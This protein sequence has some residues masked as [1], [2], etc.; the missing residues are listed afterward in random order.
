MFNIYN[1][2]S[3]LGVLNI[4]SVAI[5]LLIDQILARAMFLIAILIAA[6]I[7]TDKQASQSHLEGTE[8]EIGVMEEAK[9]NRFQ[10]F[11]NF[12]LKSLCEEALIRSMN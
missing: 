12:V 8:Q 7:I 10:I 9:N 11:R 3:N 2:V 6:K 4:G 5:V 1:S